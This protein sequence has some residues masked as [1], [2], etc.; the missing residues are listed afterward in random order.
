MPAHP[1][2]RRPARTACFLGALAALAAAPWQAQA[3]AQAPRLTVIGAG[4]GVTCAEWAAAG[5]SDPELE[6]WAFG[7]ASAVAPGAQV[8]QGGDP[9][10]K[11]DA[12][13]IHAWLAGH[14]RQRP[15]DTLS[16]ALVRIVF[17]APR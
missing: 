8:R 12:D 2:P 1:T 6:Q 16:T 15:D 3:Q 13:A 14:C 5:R 9:L 4:A 11:L 17:A 10:A 7:F